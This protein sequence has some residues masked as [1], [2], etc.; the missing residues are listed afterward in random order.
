MIFFRRKNNPSMEGALRALAV[1]L[2]AL[3]SETR[4]Q[5]KLI[6]K[7]MIAQE[8]I[9]TTLNRMNTTVAAAVNALGAAAAPSTPDASVQ[10][11]I[12]GVNSATNA[13]ASALPVVPTPTP[14][15]SP[16]TPA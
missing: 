14:A 11:L 1:A 5:N 12:D 13:L 10:G 7:V 4:E 3:A 8:T 15:P 6:R 2:G 16:A 9:D